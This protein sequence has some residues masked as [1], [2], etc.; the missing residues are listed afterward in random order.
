M[1]AIPPTHCL[2]LDHH[3]TAPLHHCRTADMPPKRRAAQLTVD[4]QG[5]QSPPR[6]TRKPTV[7]TNA[8]AI[9][10]INS[11]MLTMSGQLE[12]IALLITNLA[13]TTQHSEPVTN[14]EQSADARNACQTPTDAA[15]AAPAPG[16]T[17]PVQ[18]T[19]P[20]P[21]KHTT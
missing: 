19:Q 20:R 2:A 9:E 16:P 14:H 5:N 7:A 3:N 18:P 4:N 10:H 12:N 15:S 21:S 8:S 1:P 6:K 17:P 11:K 13:S